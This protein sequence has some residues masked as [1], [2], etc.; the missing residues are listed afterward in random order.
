MFYNLIL[1]NLFLP[2]EPYTQ[3]THNAQRTLPSIAS[4]AD[5]ANMNGEY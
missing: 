2:I 4:K 3:H 5:V 1:C